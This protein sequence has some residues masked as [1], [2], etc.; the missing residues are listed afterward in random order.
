MDIDD[1]ICSTSVRTSN[2][3]KMP[4]GPPASAT[5]MRKHSD[6]HPEGMI[7]AP[8]TDS[9]A[10]ITSLYKARFGKQ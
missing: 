9:A 6:P 1:R 4:V 3:R 10:I 8:R 5:A 2:K 7:G